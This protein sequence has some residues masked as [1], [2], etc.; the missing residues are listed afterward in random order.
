MLQAQNRGMGE[1]VPFS[2][3]GLGAAVLR[4]LGGNLGQAEALLGP[5]G[6]RHSHSSG[7][8]SFIWST[9]CLPRG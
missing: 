5:E 6:L 1:V 7:F 3:S 8:D 4:E 9:R 2:D